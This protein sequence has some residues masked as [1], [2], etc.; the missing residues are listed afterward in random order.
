M[1]SEENLFCKWGIVIKRSK[2]CGEVEVAVISKYEKPGKVEFFGLNQR[3]ISTNYSPHP[4]DTVSYTV[5]NGFVQDFRKKELWLRD[6]TVFNGNEVA[7]HTIMFLKNDHRIISNGCENCYIVETCDFAETMEKRHPLQAKTEP[8]F[9]I[10]VQKCADGASSRWRYRDDLPIVPVYRN[11]CTTNNPPFIQED[12]DYGIINALVICSSSQERLLWTEHMGCAIFPS[13]SQASLP[14][15]G[16]S[17]GILLRRTSRSDSFG[18]PVYYK[19]PPDGLIKITEKPP[20]VVKIDHHDQRI[21]VESSGR[22][23]QSFD[24]AEDNIFVKGIGLVRENVSKYVQHLRLGAS[25]DVRLSFEISP[26]TNTVVPRVEDL[27]AGDEF[28]IILRIVCVR[29]H[30]ESRFNNYYA[31]VDTFDQS[32]ETQRRIS[33]FVS[34]PHRLLVCGLNERRP[35]GDSSFLLNCVKAKIPRFPLK[36]E[37]PM[38]A[39]AVDVTKLI[40]TDRTAPF[41]VSEGN[42]MVQVQARFLKYSNSSIF[43][44]SENPPLL[45][46]DPQQKSASFSCLDEFWVLATCHFS[47]NEPEFVVL[48]CAEYEGM[49]SSDSSSNLAVINDSRDYR[50]PQAPIPHDSGVKDFEPPLRQSTPL[51]PDDS[52]NRPFVPKEVPASMPSRRALND[53]LQTEIVTESMLDALSV[54]GYGPKKESDNGSFCE[55]FSRRGAKK[56]YDSRSSS[57]NTSFSTTFDDDNRFLNSSGWFRGNDRRSRWPRNFP[58]GVRSNPRLRGD[59]EILKDMLNEFS[60]TR[61]II[62]PRELDRYISCW[63]KPPNCHISKIKEKDV[64]LIGVELQDTK[65]PKLPFHCLVR[66][67]LHHAEIDERMI[68]VPF[69]RNFPHLP[70]DFELGVRYRGIFQKFPGESFPRLRGFHFN[71]DGRIFK[72][73]DVGDIEKFR[74][75]TIKNS[76]VVQLLVQCSRPMNDPFT[77]FEL[78][79]FLN[80]HIVVPKSI[81]FEEQLSRNYDRYEYWA[82]IEPL[83]GIGYYLPSS[84]QRSSCVVYWK[85]VPTMID[86][87]DGGPRLI[88]RVPAIDHKITRHPFVRDPP[89]KLECTIAE[90]AEQNHK[91]RLEKM[92]AQ[93]DPR[94]LEVDDPNPNKE[95]KVREITL[96]KRIEEILFC[97]RKLLEFL[98]QIKTEGFFGFLSEDKVQLMI[99]D[100]EKDTRKCSEDHKKR[101]KIRNGNSFFL[102]LLLGSFARLQS[103]ELGNILLKLMGRNVVMNATSLKMSPDEKDLV[104]KLQHMGLGYD[105]LRDSTE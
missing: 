29:R 103:S 13:T 16:T 9:R 59:A 85:M 39:E 69:G 66:F 97:L 7:I 71:G 22:V 46:V 20:F 26:R 87:S 100:I 63:M 65:D 34:V 105:D 32:E 76:F 18:F 30:K 102:T 56:V 33:Q 25:C 68:V 95:V 51:P 93:K 75:V 81:I 72:Q 28:Q 15:I 35:P 37:L 45:L 73:P 49:L 61:Y 62:H 42:V 21:Y 90:S 96:E 4:G 80:D 11:F 38:V 24:A 48:K 36:D 27:L 3:E 6:W 55:S 101:E 83:P 77:C 64:H 89:Q 43:L 58:L 86:D 14:A 79:T 50:V 104:S 67:S 54:R 12:L 60:E 47:D 78:F 5:R 10:A 31:V 8:F 44:R 92:R 99:E 82:T 40:R 70:E 53:T 84:S 41:F 94:I 74:T 98:T 57:L 52:T 91:N 2:N 88:K 19:V 1:S 17:M 23:N